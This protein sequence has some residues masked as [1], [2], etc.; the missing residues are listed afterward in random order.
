MKKIKSDI[1]ASAVYETMCIAVY[2]YICSY[3][4]MPLSRAVAVIN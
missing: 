3:V 4:Y 1:F 2:I